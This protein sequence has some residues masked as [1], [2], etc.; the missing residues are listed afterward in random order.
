[1]RPYA[2][3]ALMKAYLKERVDEALVSLAHKPVLKDALRFMEPEEDQRQRLTARSSRKRTD[4]LE[5][6]RIR[7]QTSADVSIRQHAAH[8]RQQTESKRWP[9]TPWRGRGGNMRKH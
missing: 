5:H 7:Q 1:M 9:Q 3:V 6:L 4:A 8:C 2:S